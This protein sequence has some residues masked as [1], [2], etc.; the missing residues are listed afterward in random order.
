MVR[1]SKLPTIIVNI[2]PDWTAEHL[3]EVAQS[4]YVNRLS[5]GKVQ[6]LIGNYVRHVH[7][8]YDAVLADAVHWRGGS[9]RA[10]QLEELRR[11]VDQAVADRFPELTHAEGTMTDDLDIKVHYAP[12]ERP[13][14]GAESWTAVTTDEPALVA[15]CAACLEMA[16]QAAC[17]SC[18]EPASWRRDDRS[19]CGP[20]LL[21]AMETVGLITRVKSSRGGAEA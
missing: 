14:C 9:P 12:K 16:A 21:D 13:V 20:C 8:N 17:T 1:G 15:G 3:Q 10:S 6:R 4:H 5:T 7:T 11:R 2:P 18:G 19:W